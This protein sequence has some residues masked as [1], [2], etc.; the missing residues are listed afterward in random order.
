MVIFPE[1]T[2]YNPDDGK[3]LSKSKEIA[4]SNNL[5]ELQFHLTPRSRGAWLVLQSLHERLD[6]V[7]DITVGYSGSECGKGAADT[8]RSKAPQLR[9]E[10]KS[11]VLHTEVS[12]CIVNVLEKTYSS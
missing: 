11:V 10:S 8:T 3:R 7:Y 6:A 9:G 12:Y 1:G 5:Q 2:R 4:R